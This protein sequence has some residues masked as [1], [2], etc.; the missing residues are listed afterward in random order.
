MTRAAPKVVCS[1]PYP[2]LSRTVSL[3]S[4]L[5]SGGYRQPLS[6]LEIEP[7]NL[8]YWRYL[9][10]SRMSSGKMT[11]IH[12]C[13]QVISML[14]LLETEVTLT[15]LMNGWR[16]SGWQNLGTCLKW[17]SPAAMNS[18]V[19]VM[20]QLLTTSS[21]MR[22]WGRMWWMLGCCISLITSQTILLSTV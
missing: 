10:I 17:T 3:M 4:H 7:L 13:G 20:F 14:I 12:Y 1:L 22:H 18:L 21:G 19:S 9:A 11:L 16:I 2:N 15:W 8:S 6:N 5:A